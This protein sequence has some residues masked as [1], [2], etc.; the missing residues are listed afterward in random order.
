M[1]RLF[2]SDEI[3]SAIHELVDELAKREIET[4]IYVVGGAA[5][6]LRKISR[7][8][9]VD[10]DAK[11]TSAESVLNAAQDLAFRKGWPLQWFNNAARVFVPF[12]TNY[13]NWEPYLRSHNVNVYLAPFEDLLIM[14]L[15]AAR[16]NRDDED[17]RFLIRQFKLDSLDEVSAIYEARCPGEVLS[18]KAQKLVTQILG[19]VA[20]TSNGE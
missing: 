6:L 18:L 4:D 7:R 13:E 19:E 20:S 8:S 17:L 11:I 3:V 15:N 14:K 5:F 10:I 16:P 9:T 12:D 1:A 2:T